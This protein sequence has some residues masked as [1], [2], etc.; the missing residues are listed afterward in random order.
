MYND[1]KRARRVRHKA[2]LMVGLAGRTEPCCAGA[3]ALAVLEV[4]D[5]CLALSAATDTVLP[6]VLL[7]PPLRSQL[8]IITSTLF[9]HYRADTLSHIIT[10]TAPYSTGKS[11]TEFAS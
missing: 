6:F 1:V 8:D 7:H 9:S 4:A 2:A 11:R 5:D 3:G 10:S